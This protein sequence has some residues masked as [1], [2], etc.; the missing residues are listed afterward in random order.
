MTVLMMTAIIKKAFIALQL[1]FNNYLVIYKFDI[2]HS[3]YYLFSV[4]KTMKCLNFSALC[5]YLFRLTDDLLN[6]VFICKF[7][8]ESLFS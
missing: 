7:C 2:Q 5:F 1:R 3:H 6:A 4:L 8:L